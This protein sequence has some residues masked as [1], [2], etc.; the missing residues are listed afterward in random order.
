MLLQRPKIPPVKPVPYFFYHTVLSKICSTCAH[1]R[2]VLCLLVF[3]TNN[4]KWQVLTS[5][6]WTRQAQ[7]LRL[8]AERRDRSGEGTAHTFCELFISK[9]AIR[10]LFVAAV[11][12]RQVRKFVA[13]VGIADRQSC[14]CAH[15]GA[16][17]GKVVGHIYCCCAVVKRSTNVDTSRL[18]CLLL[19]FC[20]CS[21][22]I[23]SQIQDHYFIRQQLVAASWRLVCLIRAVSLPPTATT[24]LRLDVTTSSCQM[25]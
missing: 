20:F 21:F 15:G 14:R 8:S 16:S 3:G 13:R 17:C 24:K 11:R 1:T 23:S 18:P 25:T 7:L 9:A 4:Q 22:S 5:L 10:Q 12:F 19:M 6:S 2:R